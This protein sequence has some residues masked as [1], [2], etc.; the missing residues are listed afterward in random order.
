MVVETGTDTINIRAQPALDRDGLGA[1]EVIVIFPTDVWVTPEDRD[2]VKESRENDELDVEV[3][4]DIEDFEETAMARSTSLSP[5]RGGLPQVRGLGAKGASLHDPCRFAAS[6][7]PGSLCFLPSGQG[8]GVTIAMALQRS[9]LVIDEAATA[10]SVESALW[11]LEEGAVI[12]LAVEDP[13][14]WLAW[15][16][17]RVEEGMRVLVETRATTQEGAR[18]VL[19]GIDAPARAEAW[20]DALPVSCAAL[21]NGG[22]SVVA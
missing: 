15:A 7:A 17:R 14:R 4:I 1:D 2:E 18:R 11:S 22:W 19:L 5:R 6:V 9:V 12:V 21:L 16:L 20:L 10:R 8:L 3:I 13:S